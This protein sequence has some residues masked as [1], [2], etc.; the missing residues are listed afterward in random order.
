MWKLEEKVGRE[1]TAEEGGGGGE[2]TAHISAAGSEVGT[3]EA[4]VI[5]QDSCSKVIQSRH[6]LA[7]KVTH[8]YPV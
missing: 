6:R 7:I 5:F 2:E 8:P 4:T 3:G 1:E